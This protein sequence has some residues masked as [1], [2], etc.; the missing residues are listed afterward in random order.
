M[1]RASSVTWPPWLSSAVPPSF[2]FAIVLSSYYSPNR[3]PCSSLFTRSR[4]RCFCCTISPLSDL[5]WFGIHARSAMS[6]PPYNTRCAIG[7]FAF[8]E[9]LCRLYTNDQPQTRLGSPC[10]CIGP[11]IDS[12]PPPPLSLR[13]WSLKFSLKSSPYLCPSVCRT[14]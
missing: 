1:R 11:N 8:H 9:N 5:F 2:L 13:I 12:L 3:L 7:W 4:V 14:L 6:V 10:S